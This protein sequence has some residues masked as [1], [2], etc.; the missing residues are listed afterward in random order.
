MIFFKHFPQTSENYIIY[1]DSV[2][3][4]TW[5]WEDFKCL[6]CLFKMGMEAILIYRPRAYI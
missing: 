2:A 6:K 4:L 5:F 1:Q 3:K